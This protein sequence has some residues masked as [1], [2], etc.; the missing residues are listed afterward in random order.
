MCIC[1]TPERFAP[2]RL[3]LHLFFGLQLTDKGSMRVRSVCALCMRVCVYVYHVEISHLCTSVD[4]R[5]RSLSHMRKSHE[6]DQNQRRRRRQR[7]VEAPDFGDWL[8]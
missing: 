5:S 7:K 3:Q 1:I 6:S 4:A 8:V 2:S